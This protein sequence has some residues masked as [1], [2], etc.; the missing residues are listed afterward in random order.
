MKAN[1]SSTRG[2]NGKQ[3]KWEA[4]RAKNWQRCDRQIQWTTC[5][6]VKEVIHKECDWEGARRSACVEGAR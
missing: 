1:L 6:P 4:T 3:A 5:A 2:G